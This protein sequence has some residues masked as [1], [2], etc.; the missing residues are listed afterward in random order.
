LDEAL[1]IHPAELVTV[2]LYVPGGRPEILALV[3]EPV[4]VIPSGLRVSVHVPVEGKLLITTLPVATEHDGLVIAPT[5]GAEGLSF[6]D[7]E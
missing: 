4:V 2:K 1:E 6:T 5:T 3:P 7:N